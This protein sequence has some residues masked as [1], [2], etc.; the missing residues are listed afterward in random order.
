MAGYREQA[1][2]YPLSFISEKEYSVLHDVRL[3]NHDQ[4]FQID[5]IIISTKFLLFLR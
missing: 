1:I 3:S 2:D 5:T 4:Y